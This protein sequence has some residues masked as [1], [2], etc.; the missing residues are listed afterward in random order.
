MQ[1][2]EVFAL[3]AKYQMKYMLFFFIF[4]MHTFPC[5]LD[6]LCGF[7]FLFSSTAVFGFLGLVHVA[8]PLLLFAP[9]SSMM[10]CSESQRVLGCF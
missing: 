9:F 1:A 3:F 5:N 8:Q 6:M 4:I 2:I 10:A 7:F